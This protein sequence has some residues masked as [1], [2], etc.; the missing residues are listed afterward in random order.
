MTTYYS[1]QLYSNVLTR[2]VAFDPATDVIVFDM[3]ESALSTVISAYGPGTDIGVAVLM[4][5]IRT[6]T[7]ANFIF[8]DNSVIKIGDETQ[9]AGADDGANTLSLSGDG[10]LLGLGGD[11]HLTGA[12]AHDVLEGGAGNDTIQGS[13][14]RDIILGG[15]G[16]DS[17]DG[18]AGNDILSNVALPT[19]FWAA[20]GSPG[21]YN[22]DHGTLVYGNGGDD[23]IDGGPGL[24]LVV[25]D[26]SDRTQPIVFDARGSGPHEFLREHGLQR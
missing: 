25:L 3:G 18:G 6:L 23:T 26:Y 7:S 15:P 4:A 19:S 16:N 17:L 14:G 9:G 11:D 22:N 8:A 21:Y 24:D 5:D 13:G 2:T 1:S 12:G 10:R 20:N